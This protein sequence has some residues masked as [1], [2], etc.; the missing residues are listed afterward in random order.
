MTTQARTLV[1]D[2]EQ[3][4]REMVVRQLE[5]LGHA[6]AGAEDGNAA[7]EMLSQEDFD[8]VLMDLVMP[9]MDGRQLLRAVAERYPNI[10]PVVVTAHSDVQQAVECMKLGAFDFLEKRHSREDLSTTIEK[11]LRQRERQARANAME[12]AAQE[13][14]ATFDAVP[15]LVAVLDTQYRFVRVNKAMAERLGCA[16]EAAVGRVCYECA[17]ESTEPHPDCP[18]Q[19]TLFDRPEHMSEIHEER[20][21]GNLLVS[22]SPL[23]DSDGEL[24]GTVVVAR[25]IGEQKRRER[26]LKAAHKEAETL[27]TSMSSFLIGVDPDLTVSRWNA[28]AENAFGISA[29]EA[30]GKPLKACGLEWD[31][32]PFD[33]ALR[34]W[35]ET[36][37]AV[38]ISEVRYTRPDGREGILGITVNPIQSSE[39]PPHGFFLLGADIS[40]RV[41][42]EAQ[43]V[44]A[45]KLESIGGLAA[46]I[47]HEIN[48][49]T[50]YVG[51]NTEFLQGVFG[52]LH[53][54][55]GKYG[56]LTAA[57]RD[58]EVP[59][60][61]LDE[62]AAM[63]EEL[64]LEFVSEEIPRAIEQSL[65]G[66]H[67]VASI[68]HAMKDF[69]HPGSAEKSLTDLN[70]SIESTITVARNEW[71]Y[72]SEME[73]DFDPD[74]PPVSCLPGEFNQVILNMIVNAVHA[75]QGVVGDGGTEKGKI[76]IS[77]RRAGEAVEVR[78]GDS[79]GGIPEEAR[80]RIFDPFFTTK[81]VGRGTGQGL[82][83]AYNVIVD[84]HQGSLTFETETGKGT[85]FII[86]LPMDGGA[87]S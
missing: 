6:A 10:V 3:M 11:A 53:A 86:R 81:E 71:K 13:W 55:L 68:V 44:Q 70:K 28:A 82:A 18:N 65:E 67:R 77:T 72:L 87:E 15:D 27:L 26:E 80:E 60:E 69:S 1:V 34:S 66:V 7:L 37:Q 21:G 42:L 59:Q 83:I 4:F 50:Q 2:D 8:V 32:T 24:V 58:G 63:E 47:A 29:S 30:L 75:I 57:A 35:Q 74:L 31:W 25:D 76:T 78:I 73:T 9:G 48:T 14:Q 51:D 45:Q 12:Q 33:E 23:H 39:P 49:P 54:L 40:E 84:K 19:A 38:R 20:L 62:I 41:A 61:L 79:G 17:H 56:E 52:D 5:H 46:G 22:T 43:L 16:P 64:D 36:D 85:T